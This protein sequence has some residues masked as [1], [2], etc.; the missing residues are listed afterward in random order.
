MKEIIQKLNVDNVL[1]NFSEVVEVDKTTTLKVSAGQ[2]AIVFIDG[3][4]VFRVESGGKKLIFKD[5]GKNYL[6]KE[7]QIAFVKTKAILQMSW[8]FGNIQVNNER[9][10]E[11]YRVGTNGKYIVEIVDFMKLINAFS[12]GQNITV[13]NIKEKT[14]SAIKTVG[15]PI[16]SSCFAKTDVSVF[17][18]SSLIGVIREEMV[19]DLKDEKMFSNIGIKINSLTVDVVHVNQEDLELIRDRING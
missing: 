17:E 19:K 10:K 15:T 12:F 2:E 3:K 6:G 16:L 7:M 8:G 5:Y 14:L 9:L 18:I 11:A 13:D 4:A 1:V